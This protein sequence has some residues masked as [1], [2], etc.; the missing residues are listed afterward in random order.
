MRDPAAH[1]GSVTVGTGATL[2]VERHGSG[3]PVVLVHGNFASLRMWDPQIPALAEHFAVVAYDVR[4][5]GRSPLVPGR[6]TDQGDLH[7][8]LQALGIPDAH[9]VGLSMGAEI[10]MACALEYPAAVRSL[11]IVLGGIS[12]EQPAW[13]TEGFQAA[14]AAMIAGDF[15][16]A[17]ELL[18][19]FPPMRS[20]A[21]Y[22]DAK[23][24]METIIDANPWGQWL[25]KWPEH[26]WLEPPIVRRLGEI[27]APTL[28][29]SGGLDDPAFLAEADEVVSSVTGAE[30]VV[31]PNAGHMVN[32]EA[33]SEFN[34]AVTGFILRVESRGTV[35]RT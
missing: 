20:M 16:H 15:T 3:P 28:V 24:R 32:I 21:R 35:G 30:R 31:I 33:H 7:A 22:P 25:A 1:A 27:A 5:F 26:D 2:Y 34:E 9:L 8:L 6:H 18:M 10:V 13:L 4:G 17:R 19:N 29:V 12:E 23:R 11:V 14:K